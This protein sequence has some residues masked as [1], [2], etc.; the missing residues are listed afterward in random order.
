MD[1]LTKLGILAEAARFDAACTS[2]GVT[3]GPSAGKVGIASGAGLCHTFAKDGRCITLLKVLMSNACSYDC[4]YC[5]NRSSASCRRATFEPRELAELTVDFY[6]RNYIE[7]LFLSSGVLGTPDNTTERMIECLR[8]LRE[9]LH[10]NGYVHAKVIPGTSPELIE[11]IGLLADRLSANLELP[12]SSSLSN[13]C[14][15]KDPKSIV[16]SMSQIHSEREE[17]SRRILADPRQKAAL[18]K[19]H[20]R[21]GK[22]ASDGVSN[23]G[24]RLNAAA[25]TLRPRDEVGSRR[26]KFAPAGQSTQLIIGASPEDDSH[27]LRLSASLYRK[28]DLR[29]VFFSAY[30]PM[31]DDSRLPDQQTPVPLRREH[32][33][34][35]ADWLM[36]YYGFNPD[37]LVTPESP[38]LD[39]DLDPKLAWAL[40]HQERFP[41]EVNAAS[42]EELL[43]VPGIGPMGARRII[44]ARRA[45][46]LTFE[47]LKALNL[48]L[49]RARY[50]ICCN[51]VR[52]RQ[53]PLDEGLIR[54]EVAKGARQSKYNKTR[55]IAEGQLSLF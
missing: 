48:T 55:R 12:S 7:G 22:G 46:P 54:S 42:L 9:E 35:Q 18:A 19:R 51:G 23:M 14:P 43:R 33:L 47:D 13:L 17:E 50:F 6:K 34:Y 31:M 49:K 27:I 3:R 52:D 41:V 36:R 2:S 21:G 8:V 39:L 28:F 44:A 4:A 53:A 45:K 25:M 15:E 30:I 37:E 29:R 32:R 5:V 20:S 40:T 11:R 26:R 16:S 38:W 24:L 10:F 1:T